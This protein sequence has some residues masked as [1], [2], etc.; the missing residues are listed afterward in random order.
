MHKILILLSIVLFSFSFS[1]NAQKLSENEYSELINQH[2]QGKQEVTVQSGRVDILNDEY[3]IEVEFANKWKNSI[4]QALWYGQQTGKQPGIVL[5]L[6][7]NN[8]YKYFI[9]LNT[10]LDYAGLGEKVKVWLYPNDFENQKEI[11]NHQKEDQT[12]KDFWLTTS[13]KTRHNASC[14]YFHKTRGK[15]C[16]AN[17][18]IACKKCGG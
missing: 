18:G 14:K 11:E 4:G 6:K 1:L 12:N 16:S 8:D 2:F 10:A 7:S 3:A 9:Q 13:S 5:I 17:E 15:A